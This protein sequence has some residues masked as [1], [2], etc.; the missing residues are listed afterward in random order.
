VQ[1]P[2]FPKEAIYQLGR[3]Y[4]FANRF[5]EAIITFNKYKD[6]QRGKEDNIIT[7]SR[8]IEMC[9][10]AKQLVKYPRN[11]K[12]ENLGSTVNSAYPDYNPFIPEDESFIVFTTKRPD[13]L[14]LT[15]GL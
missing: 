15:I 6:I 2:K 8:M 12:F 13:C 11:V 9:F 4:M 10:N 3:A 5:D 1:Q 14:G 7:G